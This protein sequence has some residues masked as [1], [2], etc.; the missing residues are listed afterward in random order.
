MT[1]LPTCRERLSK[2]PMRIMDCKSEILLKDRG[3]GP[4][5]LITSAASALATSGA[6]E[7]LPRWGMS[8]RSIAD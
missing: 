1:S 8:Y 5:I 3:A 4:S 6:K 2:N 7:Y